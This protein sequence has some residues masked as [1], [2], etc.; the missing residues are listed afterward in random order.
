MSQFLSIPN[1]TTSSHGHVWGILPDP[2][3]SH[4][5]LPSTPSTVISP[6]QNL[7]ASVPYRNTV[8]GPHCLQG[9]SWDSQKQVSTY[10]SY[11][12]QPPQKTLSV[13]LQ[14]NHRFSRKH[15]LSPLSQLAPTVPLPRMSSHFP[16]GKFFVSLQNPSNVFVV[17]FFLTFLWLPWKLAAPLSDSKALWMEF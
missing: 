15:R 9:Q 10:L 14:K 13:T 3:F 11:F 1:S 17:F 8:T 7:L 5:S 12:F 4:S 6:K 2:S 16:P